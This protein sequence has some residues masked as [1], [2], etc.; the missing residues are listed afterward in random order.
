MPLLSMI[1][2]FRK[3]RNHLTRRLPGFTI[4][5]IMVALVITTV[6]AA[7]ATWAFSNIQKYVNSYRKNEAQNL[8]FARFITFFNFDIR[9]SESIVYVNDE[10]V[11]TFASGEETGYLFFDDCIVRSEQRLDDTLFIETTSFGVTPL[12]VAPDLIEEIDV[13]LKM[14]KTNYPMTFTKY[15]SRQQLFSLTYG[16][17]D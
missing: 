5:E 12:D 11:F 16:H 3:H 2:K 14:G 6:V 13:T 15:Y 8:D 4:L 17:T 1:N 10:L 7:M 9:Q